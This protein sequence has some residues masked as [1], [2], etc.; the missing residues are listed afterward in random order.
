MCVVLPNRQIFHNVEYQLGLL[1]AHSS[2]F[3]DTRDQQSQTNKALLFSYS[4]SES[5]S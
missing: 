4:V 1:P 3:T 5:A 2:Q